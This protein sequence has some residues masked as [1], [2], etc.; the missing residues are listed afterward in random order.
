MKTIHLAEFEAR[1][2]TLRD[3]LT[4][5]IDRLNDELGLIV[6]EDEINDP[7]D[8]A[9]LESGNQHLNALLKQ[10]RHELS[11]VEHALG[12]IASGNYGICEKSGEKISLDRLRAEPQTRYCIEHAREA[13]H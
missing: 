3:E 7:Q 13:E 5:S 2:M 8:L 11:E 12:K 10:Q 9:S 6:A 4:S 1:L